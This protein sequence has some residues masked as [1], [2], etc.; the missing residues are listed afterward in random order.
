MRGSVVQKPK[1]TGRWYVVLDLGSDASGQRQQR[2]HA[3]Y[4]TKREAERGLTALLSA[5]DSGTYVTPQRITVGEYLTDRWLPAIEDTVRPTTFDGYRR[6]V[7]LYVVPSLGRVP[8]QALTPDQLSTL[9]RQLRASGGLNGKALTPATV[10]RVHAAAHRA[11]R[12]AVNWGYVLRNPATAAMKPKQ[13]SAGSL[14]MRT[15]S[16]AELRSFLEYLRE[17]RLYA[18]WRLAA[19]TGMR[20]GEVLGLRWCDVD[21]GAGRVAVRQTITEAGSKLVFGEPKT[22]RGKRNIA[23]DAETVAALRAWRKLQ[24]EERL[25]WG[26]AW[27]DTGMV[28]TREDGSMIRPDTWSFWFQRHLRISGLPRIRFHDLRHTHASLALQAGVPAKVVSE[29]LGH[30][31]VAFTLDVYSHTIP[32]MHEEAAELVAALLQ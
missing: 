21:L 2:W 7:R 1:K 8:L 13:R 15:W 30:A 16:A 11:F 19:T 28:F 3:G 9:Y 17:D 32:A 20:R 10:V 25:A 27:Q 31:T 12:D 6:I 18:A 24:A 23:L 22:G 14:E 29:R 5:Q 4:R 26:A